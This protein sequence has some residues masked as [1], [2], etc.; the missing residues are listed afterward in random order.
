VIRYF[1]GNPN[2]YIHSLEAINTERLIKFLGDDYVFAI[3]D[4]PKIQ[5]RKKGPPDYDL[6][7]NDD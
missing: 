1:K 4:Y 6:A 7:I 3:Q 5:R 2:F